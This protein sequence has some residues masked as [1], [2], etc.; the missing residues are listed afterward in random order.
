MLTMRSS[1]SNIGSTNGPGSSSS[2]SERNASKMNICF[3]NSSNSS[4]SCSNNNNNINNSYSSHTIHNKY[5]SYR[6][7][8]TMSMSNAISNNS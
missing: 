8:S 5:T 6:S 1:R 4:N 3:S 7:R 2:M